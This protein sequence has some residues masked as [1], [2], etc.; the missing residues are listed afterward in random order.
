MG[1]VSAAMPHLSLDSII[2]FPLPGEICSRDDGHT[3]EGPFV[4]C[5]LP[6]RKKE[7]KKEKNHLAFIEVHPLIWLSELRMSA[8]QWKM[9]IFVKSAV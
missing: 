5:V 8:L 9:L 6:A 1:F 3:A 2:L 4:F 7:R